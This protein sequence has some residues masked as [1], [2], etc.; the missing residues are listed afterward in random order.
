MSRPYLKR[1]FIL[2]AM[3]AV[4]VAGTSSVL[5]TDFFRSISNNIR[6]YNSVVKNLLAE[7][8]DDIDSEELIDA[9]IEGMLRNL[10]PYTVFI[11]EE[12]QSAVT[13][14]TKGKY[15]GVGIRLGVREGTLTVISPMEGTPAQRAGVRPGDKIIKIDSISTEDL[16]TDNAARKIRGKP[17]TRVILTFERI[18]EHEPFP[19]ELT[20]EEIKINDLPYYGVQ[21]GIGYI[22]L[23]RFSRATSKQ[24]SDALEDLIKQGLTGLV[25]DLRD[26]PGGLLRDAVSMVDALVEPGVS[27]VETRGRTKKAM[28]NH[29]S[30]NEPVLPAAMPVTVLVSGGSASASEIVAGAIQDL[31]RGVIIGDRTFGKGLVQSI[32]PLNNNKSIK[33]TTAKYYIPS[34]RLIQKEDYLHNGV[35]TD[36]LDKS[37]SLFYTRSGR[38]V[39]GGG[40][41][42]PDI[43]I[44]NESLPPLSRQLWAKSMFFAFATQSGDKYNL[45]TTVVVN[46]AMVEDFQAFIADKE[47]EPVFPGENNLHDFEETLE[48]LEGFQGTVD[49]RELQT[50]F[51]GKH[52]SAFDDEREHIR[53]GLRLEFAGIAGGLAER[54]KSSLEDDVVYQKAVELIHDEATYLATLQPGGDELSG[55]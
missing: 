28:R 32:F 11:H 31:D 51:D 26:N 37:D 50:Y 27:I 14:L 18:G 9:S 29:T 40:G 42:T 7:Y 49:L 47:I 13:M 36:G 17:G 39:K 16:N 8:V 44:S 2:L 15:G 33:M 12:D 5:A 23:T 21:D 10:D 38:V 24:F 41:I 46:D 20:R 34:G 3:L 6:T 4:I 25:L 48:E 45:E 22:R 54:I 30:R 35:L 52:A 19:V 43:E 53:K 1:R 55:K